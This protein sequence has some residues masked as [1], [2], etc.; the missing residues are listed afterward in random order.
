MALK[1]IFENF[2]EYEEINKFRTFL[3]TPANIL[4]REIETINPVL[5]LKKTGFHTLD[6]RLPAKI[7][8]LND[9]E[10]KE[11]ESIDRTL[12][13][14]E[15]EVLVGGDTRDDSLYDVYRFIIKSRPSSMSEEKPEFSYSAISSEYE[16]KKVPIIN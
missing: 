16:L 3:F 10:L 2:E 5:N 7:F 8:D 9:L 1:D 6:F 12:D 13:G 15:I 11:N 14:Y 4:I